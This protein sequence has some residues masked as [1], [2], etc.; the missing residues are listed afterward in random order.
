MSARPAAEVGARAEL[1]AAGIALAV[2]GQAR[3][4]RAGRVQP[5]DDRPVGAQYLTVG[6]GAQPAQSEP[7]IGGRAE[8]EIE[9][10]PRS[11]V[12]RLQILGPLVEVGGLPERGVLVVAR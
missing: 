3:R 8:G 5:G 1:G 9:S 10:R 12:L 4:A 11:A 6:R 2:L 7:G